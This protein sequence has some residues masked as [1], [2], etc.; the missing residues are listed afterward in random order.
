[1]EDFINEE[2]VVD[3]EIY[4]AFKDSVKCPIC[5]KIL[6]NPTM[7]MKCQKT[8]CKKCIDDWKTKNDKCPNNCEKPN[9]DRSLE[10][11]NLLSKIKFRCRKC[12]EEIFYDKVEKHIEE[13]Q[14]NTKIRQKR[15][16]KINKQ[17]VA[18]IKKNKKSIRITSKELYIIILI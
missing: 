10:K 3:N 15:M 11:N 13:C 5:S 9:Y 12:F 2:T 1:M 17:D 7:C 4:Q 16:K 8:Y 6:L 18:K 14:S